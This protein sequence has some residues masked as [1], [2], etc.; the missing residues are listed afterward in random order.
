VNWRTELTLEHRVL[1]TM[2]EDVHTHLNEVRD[3]MMAIDFL[4]PAESIAWEELPRVHQ[5]IS[6]NTAVRLRKTGTIVVDKEDFDAV[7]VFRY[8]YEI[9]VAT[10]CRAKEITELLEAASLL[11]HF[12][13]AQV[14]ETLLRD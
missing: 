1:A 11:R 7:L 12:D 3:A 8:A 2:A 13:V 4:Q 5:P 14:R 10:P 6:P 9:G